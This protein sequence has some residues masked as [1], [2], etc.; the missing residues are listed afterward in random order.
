MTKQRLW[1]IID[2]LT[3][4]HQPVAKQEFISDEQIAYELSFFDQKEKAQ[5]E[6]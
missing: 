4:H 3:E 6:D 5:S 1:Q 2:F